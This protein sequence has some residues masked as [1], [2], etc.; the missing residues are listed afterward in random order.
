MLKQRLVYSA[1]FKLS[2]YGVC[3]QGYFTFESF[4]VKDD[5]VVLWRLSQTEKLAS[6]A[7]EEAQTEEGMWWR[8]EKT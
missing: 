1:H 8:I 2:L 3:A 4:L 6:E 7:G 5:C